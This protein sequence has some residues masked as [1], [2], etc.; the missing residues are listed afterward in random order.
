MCNELD[1]MTLGEE[2]AQGLGLSVKWMRTIFLVSSALLAGASVSFAGLLGFVGL[3]VP[4]AI[5]K[6]TG[7]ESKKLLP[8]C[9]ICGATFVTLCDLCSRLLFRPYEV[10]VGIIMSFLGGPF[11]LWLLLKRKGGYIR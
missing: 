8:L 9:A 6:M 1:I 5:R 11:F 3:I 4:H 7:S 10:P 2:T